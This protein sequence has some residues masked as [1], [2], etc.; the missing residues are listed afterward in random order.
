MQP[1]EC[2]R[3]TPS[4]PH[5]GGE[6][7]RQWETEIARLCQLPDDKLASIGIAELNLFVAKG[8]PGTEN[9]DP[10]ACL[11]KIDDWTRRVRGFTE[12]NWRV[13]LE[14]PG[15]F[16]NSHGNFKMGAMSTFLSRHLGVRYNMAF[17]EGDYNGSDPRNLFLHGM[18]GGDGGTCVTMPL[19]YIAI[20]RRLGYPLHL[21]MAKEHYFVRWEDG[22]ERFNI[23]ATSPGFTP[24][25]DEDFHVRPRPLSPAEI[26]QGMYLRNFRPRD[27]LAHFLSER[28][29]CLFYNLRIAEAAKACEWSAKISPRLPGG[30]FWWRTCAALLWAMYNAEVDAFRAGRMSI[31]LRTLRMPKLKGPRE[32]QKTDFA[33]QVELV[34][35]E[36]LQAVLRLGT[37]DP[38][39]PLPI[40]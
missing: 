7:G 26:A 40:H 34:A 39:I 32:Q 13:F 9:L 23:E 17:C 8:L 24:L 18:L 5:V 11:K 27:V 36:R 19:L 2:E 30:M 29:V 37:A 20:G 4:S 25:T 15:T 10:S 22:Q 6:A 14:S 33:R 3:S 12:A 28:G 31:D 35:L 38:V 21:V 1:V 16:G